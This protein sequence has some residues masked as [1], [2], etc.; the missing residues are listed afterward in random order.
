MLTLALL[1]ARV[2][3]IFIRICMG[4]ITIVSIAILKKIVLP[5]FSWVF[6]P[7]VWSLSR[8][9]AI[10]LVLE[11]PVS[12]LY[13]YFPSWVYSD[14]SSQSDPLNENGRKFSPAGPVSTDDSYFFHPW[15]LLGVESS[16]RPNK[17][18]AISENFPVFSHRKGFVQKLWNSNGQKL[19]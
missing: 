12:S 2:I 6:F 11:K 18:L 13:I 14:R 5:C 1:R 9:T 7:L 4:K 8:I 15:S 17:T 16:Q 19:A 3:C 10:M